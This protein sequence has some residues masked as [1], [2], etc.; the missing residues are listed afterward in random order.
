MKRAAVPTL[1]SRYPI[2]ERLPALYAADGFAQRF[3]S[4]LD[5]VLA[6]I[7]ST[8]DNLAEYL[9]PR[10]T[11]EDFVAWLAC[12]VAADLAPDWP[13]QARR[14]AVAGAVTEHRW[15]G[16]ARGL[17]EQL[18]RY[19]GVHARVYDGGGVAWST[20][21]GAALPGQPTREVVVE[22]WPAGPDPVDE[23]Q[24][25]ALVAATCPIHLSSSV[26]VLPGPNRE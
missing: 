4:G 20:T 19:A 10:L 23:Q 24:V 22:V 14:M 5:V 9:D 11:P 2:G 15:R 7:L 3:T 25:A 17:V 18:L 6:P 16:T 1:P 8:L 21:S 13:S 12:W 26:R